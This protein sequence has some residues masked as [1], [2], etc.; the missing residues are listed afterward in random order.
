MTN[1]LKLKED[2]GVYVIQCKIN[3]RMYIGS[4]KN[5]KERFNR[6]KD[7]LEKG[8]HHCADLQI[9][10]NK[11]GNENFEIKVL[12]YCDEANARKRE[13]EYI[14][15]LNI[16]KFGYNTYDHKKSIN[17]KIKLFED[18]LFKYAT[19]NGYESDGRAYFFDFFDLSRNINMPVSKIIKEMGIDRHGK[20]NITYELSDHSG[21]Y[22]GSNWNNDGIYFVVLNEEALNKGLLDVVYCCSEE[23]F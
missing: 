22:V 15:A 5:L 1:D 9:D 17:T 3:G 6:H 8:I 13:L 4:S 21:E 14:D 19:E 10:Y 16:K 20:W 2:S 11:Y 23:M 18:K 12:E 7:L